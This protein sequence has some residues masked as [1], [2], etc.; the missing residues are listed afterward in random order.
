MRWKPADY[1][2]WGRALR[3]SGELARPERLSHLVALTAED[4]APAI[5]NCR[6]YGDACLNDGGK[7]VL[8]TRLDRFLGFD[9]ETGVLKAEAV[10]RRHCSQWQMPNVA[11]TSRAVNRTAPHMQPPVRS[12]LMRRP[13]GAAPRASPKAP[14]Y[15]SPRS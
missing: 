11:V 10:Q 15:P 3:A 14:R 8:T 13:P 1:T 5:G 7:A 9:P 4:P 12:T 2:G 6:S